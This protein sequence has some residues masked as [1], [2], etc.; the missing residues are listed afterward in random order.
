MRCRLCRHENIKKV[1]DLNEKVAFSVMSDNR[2]I[3]EPLVVY[4]CEECSLLQKDSSEKKQLAYFSE[5]NSHQLSDGEE[6][7]KFY[8]GKLVP[9]SQ[10]IVENIAKY[11]EKK[12]SKVLDIGTGNGA[13]LKSLKMKFP[14]MDLYGQD[15]QSNSKGSVLQIIKE[16]KFIIDDIKNIDEKFD[17]ISMIH[18]LNHIVDLDFFI[19]QIIRLLD[20]EGVFVVQVPNIADSA[21]DLVIIESIN[22][23]SPASIQQLLGK[24]FT[25]VV[26]NDTIYGELTIVASN[27]KDEHIQESQSKS[28]IEFSVQNFIQLVD[29]LK[30]SQEKLIMFGTS[31]LGTFFAKIL[32]E[33]LECFIDEDESRYQKSLLGKNI[34]YPVDVLGRNKKVVLPFFNKKLNENIKN[35]YKELEFISMV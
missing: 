4:L 10:L 31:P 13:F 22:H 23:F 9:R 15:L 25:Q 29:L 16:D 7:M 21:S 5:F 18:V 27:R 19:G 2:V 14:G 8:N 17:M 12:D 26:I 1:I 11:I 20:K 32:G 6:Q 34:L 30:S 35:R 3:E 28:E 24:Y 33:N